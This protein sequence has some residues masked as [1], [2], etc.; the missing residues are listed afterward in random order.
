MLDPHWVLPW[1]RHYGRERTLAAGAFFD[2]PRMVGIAPLC[3]R[4]FRYPGGLTFKRLEFLGTGFDEPDSVCSDFLAIIVRPGYENTVA[5][6]FVD[7][8]YGDA[9]GTWDEC[10]LEMIDAAHPTLASLRMAMSRSGHAFRET[11]VNRAPFIQLPGDWE[12]FLAGLGKK[13][14][15]SIKYALRD[16]EQWARPEGYALQRATDAASLDL[17]FRVLRDLHEERWNAASAPGVF[18]SLRFSAF[19]REVAERLLQEGKLELTWLVVGGEPVAAT[20]CLLGENR[21]YFYQS[22]RR[23]NVPAKIRLGIVILALLTQKFMQEGFSE[24]DFLAGDAQYKKLFATGARDLVC[25]RMSRPSLRENARR[26]LKGVRDQALL[27]R[28][29]LSV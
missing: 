15:Q 12:T 25:L 28:K 11:V 5:E 13:R 14:R 20:Y 1:W 16:F 7:F 24:F 27:V 9:F 26:V 21:V 22:G 17:G 29:W 3:S 23:M 8:L 4:R 6:A 18:A 2:G 10:V 19:H